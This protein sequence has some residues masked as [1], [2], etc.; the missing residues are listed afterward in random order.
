M[1]MLALRVQESK[2]APQPHNSQALLGYFLNHPPKIHS[3]QRVLE[4]ALALPIPQAFDHGYRRASGRKP[5]ILTNIHFT[6]TRPI[7]KAVLRREG[8][9]SSPTLR[10]SVWG[11]YP[12]KGNIDVGVLVR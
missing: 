6:T 11:E 12:F 7:V 3:G 10:P 4:S 9:W 5:F 2:H 8:C 1:R